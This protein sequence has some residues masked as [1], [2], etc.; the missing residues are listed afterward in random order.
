MRKEPFNLIITHYPGYDNYVVVREQLKNLFDSIKIVDTSQSIILA[1]VDDPYS[2]V[3]RIKS[4]GIKE[5][6]ILRVIPVDAVTDVFVDRIKQAVH[7]LIEKKVKP[8]ETFKIKIDGRV[9]RRGEGSVERIHR[10]EAI[11]MI[12]ENIHNPVNLK[13]PDWLVYVKTLRIYRS[14]ELASISV[15]RPWNIISFAPKEDYIESDEND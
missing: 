12:A 11:K 4:S 3:E 10:D 1:I 5:T 15:C 9:Y 6:P 8:E 2:A 14:T 13:N 7:E